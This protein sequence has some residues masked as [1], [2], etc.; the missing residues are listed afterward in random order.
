MYRKI[1][2]S[3]SAPL[4]HG[5]TLWDA[6]SIIESNELQAHISNVE[7]ET[8]GVSLTRNP[9]CAEVFGDISLVLDQEAICYNYPMKPITRYG[10]LGRD[11]AEE[12]VPRTI[13]NIRRYIVGLIWN[14]PDKLRRLRRILT[15]NI[16]DPQVLEKQKLKT[17]GPVNMAWAMNTL[18]ILAEKYGFNLDN[19]FLQAKDLID[20]FKREYW[21]D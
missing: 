6:I 4:Y 16:D 19:N 14:R 8:Y 13:K 2:A 11:I 18:I 5:T 15:Q 12:R 7:G 21:Q 3:K 17:N 9:A 1:L 20:T 10:L